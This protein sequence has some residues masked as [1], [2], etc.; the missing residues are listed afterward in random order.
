MRRE[1]S[2][3][4]KIKSM[5]EGRAARA[6]A[7]AASAFFCV[8]TML[9]FAAFRLEWNVPALGGVRDFWSE[10]MQKGELALDEST[11]NVLFDGPSAPGREKGADVKTQGGGSDPGASEEGSTGGDGAVSGG[12]QSGIVGEAEDGISGMSGADSH[13]GAD[14]PENGKQEQKPEFPYY[15]RINRRQN[16][17]TVYTVDEGGEYTIPHRAMLCST[18]LYNATPTGTFQISNKY[19]WRELYGGVYGQYATR[20]YRGILFHSVPY[21]RKDKSTLSADKYNKLGQ[22]AS[23]GCV[24]LTVEDA[25]WIVENCP[26][27]TT[28]EIYDD[29]DPGPLGKPE[30]SKIDLDDPRKGWDPTDPDADNPW[31][32]ASETEWRDI[33]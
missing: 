9:E 27:G 26:E 30:A 16:C 24:R 13:G 6:F 7:V 2:G 4:G 21:Y 25:K 12:N 8:L 28:V 17:I 11:E 3:N 1:H 15:I 23:M 5:M 20:I 33:P 14:A 32:E 18:G 31:R 22:Q 19:L 10:E 29:D